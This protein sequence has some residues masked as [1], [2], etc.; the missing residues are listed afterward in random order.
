M[1]RHLLIAVLLAGGLLSQA[2]APAHAGWIENG[3]AINTATND[4][5]GAPPV[6]DGLG[7][8]IM[9]WQSYS[10]IY[11]QRVDG[12]GNILWTT[13]G[14]GICKDPSS[15]AGPVIV[16]DGF[17]G[18]IITWWDRR[19]H[20][21]EYDNYAQRVDGSG[22][23]LW[24]TDGVP[25]CTASGAQI[26]PWLAADGTGGAIIAWQDSRGV[27]Y[28][29]YAQRVDASGTAVWTANGVA[30]CTAANTQNTIRVVAD[31]FGG[32]VISWQ[33]YRSGVTDIYAQRVNGTG[34][35]MWLANGEP[36]CTAV[37]F[38]LDPRLV[39]DG[40]GGAIVTWKDYRSGIEHDIYTQRVD[41]SGNVLW[42]TNGVAICTATDDQSD[43]EIATDGAGGAILAWRDLRSGTAN[44]IYAQ[45]VNGSGSALWTADG[46]AICSAAVD[47]IGPQVASDGLGGAIIA[48]RDLRSGL[49]DIY[50][51]RVDGSGTPQW[52]TDGVA[53]CTH[54]S[55][56][57]NPGLVSDGLGGA[58]PAVMTIKNATINTFALCMVR[59]PFPDSRI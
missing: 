7:G 19:N 23:V 53:I 5:F 58:V 25:V 42:T 26:A 47:Q 50:A 52:T 3:T 43:L 18:A 31:E 51:R 55:D 56:Q 34:S 6:S 17:G 32:A 1:I 57:P 45:R 20:P 9:T 13:S 44:D 12:L 37:D 28:D 11:A 41:G 15:Q 49:G 24:T 22:N 8:A 2:V 16:A 54:P 48:W 35:A 29:V 4:Q 38:Q 36:V 59:L 33:D 39:S 14:V 21:T 27:S 40:S 10:D 30:I 46:V